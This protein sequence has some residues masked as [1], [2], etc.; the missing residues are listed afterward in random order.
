MNEIVTADQS[1]P[2]KSIT[3]TM[4]ARYSMDPSA[5]EATLRG[6]IMKPDKDGK[7]A[8]REEFAAFLVVANE[9][10]LNPLTK[11]IYAFFDRQRGGVVPIVGVDGWSR[12][13]NEHKAFNGMSFVD[14]RDDG[15]RLISITCR[16]HRKDRD[17]P[18][19]A[20]EYLVEC[21]RDT[22]PWK[23][24]PRRMLRHKAMIQAA[25]Y[26][27]GFSGIYDPDEAE[28]LA[29]S[30]SRDVT[31]TL[32]SIQARLVAASTQPVASIVEHIDREVASATHQ[33]DKP[34][35]ER[36][37]PSPSEG[38]H[39]ATHSPSEGGGDE[40]AIAKAYDEGAAAFASGKP[41]TALPG[42]YRDADA[43][44]L[45][46]AWENGWQDK[47]IEDKDGA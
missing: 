38:S 37:S 24:W 7:T 10:N 12:I 45:A 31:P 41:M 39:P 44:A 4:A 3:A 21:R 20:T 36:A 28:R 27:F 14:E 2:R 29:S 15:G 26:A 22:L 32:S 9:Y 18:I 1:A 16:M 43:Q 34:E 11:E 47:N 40:S 25:R 17:H 19:E 5:F 23:T 35:T 30:S 6:T 46:D 42:A 8:T 33:N 13:I